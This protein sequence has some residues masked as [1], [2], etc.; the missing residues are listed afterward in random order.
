MGL[1]DGGRAMIATGTYNM[2][3]IKYFNFVGGLL[4]FCCPHCGLEIEIDASDGFIKYPQPEMSRSIECDCGAEIKI[5]MKIAMP[6]TIEY[7]IE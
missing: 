6:V 7:E 3:E 5:T 2:D 4:K 1:F